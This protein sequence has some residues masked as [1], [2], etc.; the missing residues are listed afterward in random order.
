[1][2]ADMM[3]AAHIEVDKDTEIILG[4]GAGSFGSGTEGLGL[5]IIPAKLF[6]Y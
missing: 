5:K 2:D 4:S 3:D 6:V 1:M